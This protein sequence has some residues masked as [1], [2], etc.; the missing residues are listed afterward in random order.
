MLYI[1]KIGNPNR[2][3]MNIFKPVGRKSAQTPTGQIL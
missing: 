2:V 1:K 3:F